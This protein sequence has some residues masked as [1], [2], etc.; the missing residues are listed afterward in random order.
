M[1]GLME[2]NTQEIGKTTGSM[3]RYIRG[4]TQGL[5][6]WLDGRKYE[7]EFKD[8]FKFGYGVY[9]WGDGRKYEGFY[10]FDKKH[11]FGKY[12]W[13][14][15]RK[16]VGY[17]ENGKQHGYGKYYLKDGT[18]KIGH[19]V[20]GKRIKWLSQAELFEIKNDSKIDKILKEN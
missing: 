12:T 13:V 1:N 16:Y 8:N 6:V 10:Q 17:W 20:T 2:V 18:I 11:G 9:E 5:Y 19:W 7:G 14:D 4:I 15:G 3:E